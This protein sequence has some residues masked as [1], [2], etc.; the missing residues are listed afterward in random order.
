MFAIA[1]IELYCEAFPEKTEMLE[2]LLRPKRRHTLLTELGRV[3]QPKSDQNGAFHWRER[4]VSGL[5][6]AALELAETRPAAKPGVAM[7]R[8]FRRR[9]RDPAAGKRP[10]PVDG[11]A[12]AGQ[13]SRCAR[14]D[15]NQRPAD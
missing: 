13:A 2:W 11:G 4:D 9:H 14:E 7:V 5:I 12:P 8:D 6:Q 3:A 10:G 1:A 15:S